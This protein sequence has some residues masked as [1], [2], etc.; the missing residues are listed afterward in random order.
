MSD[1]TIKKG[2]TRVWS[3][4]LSDASSTKL[5]LTSATVE[6]RLR[7]SEEDTNTFFVRSTGGT[8]S[9]YISITTP[10]TSGIVTITPT[11]SDWT[12]ISDWYGCFVGEWKVTDSNG[13]IQYTNDVEINIEQA[14]I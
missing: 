13:I 6:F 5:N 2:D 9:D 7:Q 14:L 3:F 11:A 8:G 4:T 12:A 10:A 1:I